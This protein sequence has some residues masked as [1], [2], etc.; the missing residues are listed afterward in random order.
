MTDKEIKEA[1]EFY[2]KASQ[3]SLIYESISDQLMHVDSNEFS[4]IAFIDDW[5]KE[6]DTQIQEFNENIED[7]LV[8]EYKNR[9]LNKTFVKVTKNRLGETT[10]QIV[11]VNGVG[12]VSYDKDIFHKYKFAPLYKTS[13]SYLKIDMD[14][15]DSYNS[16]TNIIGIE[17]IERYDKYNEKPAY[18]DSTSVLENNMIG[19][20]VMDNNDTLTNFKNALLN[21]DSNKKLTEL[22]NSICSDKL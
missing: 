1:F 13:G 2:K 22:I 17:Y 8:E 4:K 7:K 11:Y 16:K 10:I 18:L 3:K 5:A 19:W 12:D 21:N 20:K 9:V 6:N 14:I 15:V